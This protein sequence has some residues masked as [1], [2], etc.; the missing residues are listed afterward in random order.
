MDE[1]AD[2]AGAALPVTIEAPPGSEEST[3]DDAFLRWAE[4]QR[5]QIEALLR[6]EGAVLLRGF[7]V[8]ST[9][10]F[11]RFVQ[12]YGERLMSYAGGNSPRV[13]VR[14]NVYTSTE[15][16]RQQEI[17]LHHE[18]S[19]GARWPRHLFFFCARVADEGGE[20]IIASGRRV[21]R[22]LPPRLVDR[23]A[24]RG[25]LYVQHLHAGKGF[26]RSWQETFETESTEEVEARCRD[27]GMSFSWGPKRDLHLEHKGAGLIAHPETGERLWF[28]Q[29]EQWHPSSLDPEIE[30]TLRECLPPAELPLNSF[31][32][33][34]GELDVDD[35]RAVREACRAEAVDVR[36]RTHDVLL[37]DNLLVLHGRRPFKGTRQVLVA[38]VA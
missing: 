2:R 16:P 13:R 33:D 6:R 3:T 18:L 28:N 34:R 20:T 24:E 31:H 21:T 17:S 9:E 15:Y 29:A 23:F 37:L 11:E 27:Q 35:L 22:R 1:A 12:G 30:S 4:D 10:T 5:P 32:G 7:A 38:M 25:V 14:G 26:G 8:R 19:Y 36:W